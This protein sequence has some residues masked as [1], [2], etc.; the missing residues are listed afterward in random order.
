M[1][2]GSCMQLCLWFSALG[3]TP[4]KMPDYGRLIYLWGV[5]VLLRCRL[6]YFRVLKDRQ[7]RCERE[8]HLGYEKT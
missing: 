4:I 5:H 3:F 1:G 2:K 6:I 7:R 8:M